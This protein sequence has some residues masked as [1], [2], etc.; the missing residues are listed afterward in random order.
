MSKSIECE[1]AILNTLASQ[2]RVPRAL[3]QAIQEQP[4]IM[5]E[6]GTLAPKKRRYPLPVLIV[7]G[8]TLAVFPSL[9]YAQQFITYTVRPGDTLSSI[10][11]RQL[12]ASWRWKEI[13]QVNNHRLRNAHLIYPGQQ[14]RFAVSNPVSHSRKSHPPA[15]SMAHH[16][17]HHATPVVAPVVLPK[18]AITPASVAQP[19]APKVP[20]AP[21]SYPENP[22]ALMLLRILNVLCLPLVAFG[23]RQLWVKFMRRQGP[24]PV[25]APIPVSVPAPVPFWEYSPVE[26]QSYNFLGDSLRKASLPPLFDS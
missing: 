4:W 6:S 21:V 19:V 23:L 24:H 5:S 20:V 12:G 9:S 11:T 7:G 26:G 13:Y 10:A 1:L 3:R 15:P 16:V 18:G 22:M 2:G 8:M 25:V 14:L 17:K